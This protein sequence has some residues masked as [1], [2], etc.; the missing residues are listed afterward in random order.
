[1]LES[2]EGL[3]WAL[4]YDVAIGASASALAAAWF[5]ED[6]HPHVQLLDHR[7]GAHWLPDEL[8][9]ATARHSVEVGYDNIGD[10]I[11]V[12]QAVT[13]KAR[14][15]ARR[16]K[17]LPV[18]EVA[19]ATAVVAAA[20]DQGTFTHGEDS[21][22]DAAVLNAVWRESNGSRLLGRKHGKDIS[23]MLACIHALAAASNAKVK[24]RVRL[25]AVLTG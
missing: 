3:P 11:A 16:L 17:A 1:M 12:A 6:G 19:A 13:R 15:D 5:D 7:A 9:K 24:T 20:L 21:A 4:G 2:P 10:N 25:P 18:R 8:Q 23:P 22:L 14:F